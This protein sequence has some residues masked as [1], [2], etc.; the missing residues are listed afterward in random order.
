MGSAKLD[1]NLILGEFL[2]RFL[3]NF[4]HWDSG[5]DF[6]DRYSAVCATLGRQV[7]I[8]VIGR[9]NRTGKALTINKVGALMLDDGFEVN[10]GDVVHLR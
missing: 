8:E 1:R 9:A 2:N 3:N 5:A 10:V 4:E 7:Q 6:I